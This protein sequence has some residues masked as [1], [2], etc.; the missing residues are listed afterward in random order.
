[1]RALGL[2]TFVIALL[3]V[4]ALLDQETGV[5]IWLEL[6]DDLAASTARVATLARE[7]EALARE[8]ETLEAEPAAIDRAIREELDLVLPGEIVVRFA[9]TDAGPAGPDAQAGRARG[10]FAE[11]LD[12]DRSASAGGVGAGQQ[13]SDWATRPGGVDETL[14]QESW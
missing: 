11:R 8:I 13:T 3:A 6:R 12:F 2:G 10:R 7:N 9:R 4:T 14:E 5:G 1:V